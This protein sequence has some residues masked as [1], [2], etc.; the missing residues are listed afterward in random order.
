M[1]GTLEEYFVSIGVKGQN[2][3]L[4][5]IA[6]VK[7]EAKALSKLT[8]TLNMGGTLKNVLG[9]LRSGIGPKAPEQPGGSGESPDEKKNNKKLNENLNKFANGT[10]DFVKGIA[11]FD[12]VGAVQQTISSM[13]SAMSGLAKALPVV[14][15]YLQG[16]PKGLA[17]VSNAMVGMASGAVE[18]AKSSAATQYGIA[19]RNATTRYYGGDK[20]EI[21]QSNL[22]NAQYSELIMTIGS[23]YGKIGKPM[24]GVLNELTA[25][26]NTDALSRVASGNWASTGTDK[27]WVLQQISDQTRGLPPSIAQAFQAS[28][29]RNNKDLIQDKGEERGAQSANATWL[30]R[31][32]AQNEAV[33]NATQ[34]QAAN[35]KKLNDSFNELQVSLVTVGATLS[36]AVN[37]AASSLSQLPAIIDRVDATMKKLHAPDWLIIGK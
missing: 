5:N 12:P 4:S 32:E 30:N 8:P 13:G 18:I 31:G 15:D 26:K 23:A 14:G 9:A 6:K 24:Q 22:S 35:L 20:R 7:K 16:L 3:V 21:G 28:M 1:A 25:S 29:L 17:E 36:G 37:K 10:K 33:F 34:K 2:V 27:G 19:N 11:H